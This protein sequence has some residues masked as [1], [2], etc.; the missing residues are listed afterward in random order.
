MY[1]LRV[2][3][4]K[5]IYLNIYQILLYYFNFIHWCQN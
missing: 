3:D 5:N 1:I 4:E 2:I